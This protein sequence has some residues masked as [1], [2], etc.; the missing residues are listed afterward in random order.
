MMFVI[1]RNDGHYVAWPGRRSSYTRFLQ[2]ARVF[3]TR[4]DAEKERC[5]DNE[6][7]VNITEI[8]EP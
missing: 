7:V 2:Y 6:R 5:P 8:M 3:K 4:A 1:K